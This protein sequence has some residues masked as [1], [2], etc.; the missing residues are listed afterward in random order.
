[1]WQELYKMVYSYLYN[2]GLGHEDAEDVAQETLT[3][4]YLHLDG[5]Q[6]G[7]LKAWLY[8]VARRK[9]IDWLRRNRKGITLM[10]FDDYDI[11]TEDKAPEKMFLEKEN[12]QEIQTVMEAL[13]KLER[14]LL[15]LKYNLELSYEDIGKVLKMKTNTVRVGLYRARQHFKEEYLKLRRSSHEKGR[16][17]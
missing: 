17:E 1:M 3:A 4:V 5:V 15:I 16:K 13:S 7:K 6:E 14:D 8:T 2:L 10:D 12:L 9:Y 11:D